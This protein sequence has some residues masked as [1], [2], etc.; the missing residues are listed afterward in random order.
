VTIRCVHGDIHEYPIVSAEIRQMKVA[1]NSH[2]THPVILGTDW[3]GFDKLMG[4]AARVRSCQ[5]GS[6]DM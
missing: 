4:K 5:T 6:C 3:P 1:F 2:L